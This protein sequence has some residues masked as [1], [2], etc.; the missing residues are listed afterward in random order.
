MRGPADDQSKYAPSPMEGNSKTL[1]QYELVEVRNYNNS[2]VPYQMVIRGPLLI[3]VRAALSVACAS[4]GPTVG[5]L[6][7]Q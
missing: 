4:V 5:P 1:R 7:V 2:G 6:R 3:A